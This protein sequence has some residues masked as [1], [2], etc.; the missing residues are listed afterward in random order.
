MQ[1]SIAVPHSEDGISEIQPIPDE[2]VRGWGDAPGEENCGTGELG[3]SRAR[4]CDSGED[5]LLAVGAGG[6]GLDEAA[7]G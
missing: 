6:D 1:V 7:V 3:N 4:G 2:I 5:R